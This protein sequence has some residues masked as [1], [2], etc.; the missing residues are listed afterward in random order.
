MKL[1]S[2][3]LMTSFALISAALTLHAQSIPTVQAKALN[4]S[5]V[6][7]PKPGGQQILVIVIGFSKKSG[8]VSRDW[9][10]HLSAD[11]LQDSRV[12]YY[13][14]PHLEG[15]PSFVR[16]MIVRGMRKSVTPQ[17]QSHFVPL[18]EKQEE[19][20]KAVYFNDPDDAYLIV[21]DPEGHIVWQSHGSYSD[22]GHDE[23][24]KAVSDLLQK[25]FSGPGNS[26]PKT[27]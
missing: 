5:E 2:L 9:G 21:A 27:Q 23:L 20:K 10:K 19:W 16:P 8:D 6:A 22:S 1:K 3:L 12:V 15:A 13:Q 24:K 11:Y 7:F 4:D 14:I 26:K 18:Y 25:S 17:E